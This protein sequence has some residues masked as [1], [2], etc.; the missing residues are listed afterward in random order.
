[1]DD[2]HLLIDLH[3]DAPRLGPGGDDEA[4]AAIRLSGLAARTA[5]RI[6]DARLSSTSWEP[7][8]RRRTSSRRNGP[9]STYTSDITPASA[10]AFTLHVAWRIDDPAAGQADT[11]SDHP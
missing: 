9:R 5:L 2:L 4:R 10:T 1:M 3:L 6:A 8:S 11:A 7:G